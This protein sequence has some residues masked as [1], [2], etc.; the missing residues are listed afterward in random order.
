MDRVERA[1]ERRSDTAGE[2]DNLPG[3]E[4]LGDS[5][6]RSFNGL[7]NPVLAIRTAVE[8][9]SQGSANLDPSQ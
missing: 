2:A 3:D 8:P 9:C 5:G 4:S 6:Q 7:L 1:Q